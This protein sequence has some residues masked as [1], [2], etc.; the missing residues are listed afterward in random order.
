MITNMKI[1]RTWYALLA[2][3]LLAQTGNVSGDP[4]DSD[5]YKKHLAA[6]R[7]AQMRRDL[8]RAE[9]ELAECLK[10]RKDDPE[11][12]FLAARTAR[13]GGDLQKA[14]THL[15]ECKR[16]KGDVSAISLEQLLL[17]AQSGELAVLE[18]LAKL[19]GDKHP[20]TSL[21]LEALAQGYKGSF[22]YSEAMA[23]LNALLKHDPKNAHAFLEQAWIWLRWSGEKDGKKTT[24]TTINAG[25]SDKAAATFRKA[26]EI[27]PELFEARLGLADLQLLEK[28][29]TE[30]K[31]NLD[32][33]VERHSKN[34]KVQL[35]L[36]QCDMFMGETENAEKRLVDLLT[37]DPRN[38][39][40]WHLRGKL[41]GN[42]TQS[43]KWFRRALEL[44]PNA[45]EFNYS[46]FVCLMQ[47]GKRAEA[48]QFKKNYE[49][50]VKDLTHLAQVL[51]KI[52][53]KPRDVA[54][55]SEAGKIFLQL[56][57]DREGLAMLYG[58]LEHDPSHRTTH[59][60][61]ADYFDRIRQTEKAALHR[62][63]A[64]EEK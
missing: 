15:K 25:D 62:K 39:A 46:L 26:L 52:D 63:K 20:E 48:G 28:N 7:A 64:E 19:T 5:A 14:E 38:A 40:A 9:A 6:A 10:I 41:A 13:R 23:S 33:L 49:R 12:H 42:P 53:S 58:V 29:I 55:R 36:A 44:N 60:V 31:K 37:R 50:I 30:A 24:W 34:P 43:E 35:L 1:T 47:T 59:Q 17:R 11:V 45:P 2:V 16:F 57:Q 51:G 3:A 32:K 21:I 61:L 56:G 8:I 27:D 22:R 4:G 18:N 54:L